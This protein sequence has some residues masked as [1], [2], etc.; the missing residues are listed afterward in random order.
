[1]KIG[2]PLLTFFLLYTLANFDPWSCAAV[3]LWIG[4]VVHFLSRLNHTIAFR[5]YILVM[6]GLNYLFSPAITY[7]VT[8]SISVYKMRLNPEMYFSVAIPAMLCLHAGLFAIKTKIFNLQFVTGYVQGLVNQELMKKWLI[9]GFLISFAPRF[10][11]GDLGFVAYLLGALKY[12]AVYALFIIDRHKFRWFL[13]G[14]AFLEVS[15][16]LAVGMFHDVVVWSLFFGMVWCYVDKPGAA[17]KTILGSATIVML[18]VLQTV[19]GAYR[20]QLRSGKAGG[21][22]AFSTAVDKNSG[23]QSNRGGMF[24]MYNLAFS[25]TRANQGWIFSSAMQ[26]VERKRNFQGMNLIKKYAEAA[27][28]PRA[29][30]PN[31]LEAGDTKIFN[32]FSGIKILKGTSMGLGL[33]AD[34]YISYGWWGAV[35]FALVFGLL[36]ALIF[37][38][39]E[40]WTALSPFFAIFCFLL[41]N[42]AVRAD[43]ETQTWMGHMVK[44]VIVYSIVV[45]F[46]RRYFEKQTILQTAKAHAEESVPQ[47]VPQSA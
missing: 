40:K 46:A 36:C 1:M 5:E 20:E 28:L 45:Y 17:L 43:C 21:F 31:K 27:F 30:A 11:P 19:K 22:D 10:L 7:E 38:L 4:Y 23:P 24:S 16:S 18:F 15:S 29:L 32:E 34:G 33:F 13:Y 44:G 6:Y 39:I 41:L 8:Q 9:F 26:T 14:L 12:L 47:L 42:Y 35:L 3:A 2:L 37:R 25:L